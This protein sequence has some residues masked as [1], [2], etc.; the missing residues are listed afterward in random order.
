MKRINSKR[1]VTGILLAA[2]ALALVSVVQISAAPLTAPSRNVAFR[3]TSAAARV[4]A[5]AASTHASSSAWQAYQAAL[6]ADYAAQ[7]AV[8]AQ[9][10]YGSQAWTAARY[11]SAPAAQPAYRSQAWIAAHPGQAIDGNTATSP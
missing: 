1:K 3:N 2:M 10:A 6:N 11:G 4:E 8:A 5:E 9:P 7:P